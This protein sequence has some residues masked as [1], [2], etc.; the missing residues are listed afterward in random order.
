MAE[1]LTIIQFVE[2]Y[3]KQYAK[4]TY[5]REKVGKEWIETTYEQTRE[6]AHRIGAGLMALGIQKG[7]KMA[8]LSDG[9]NAWV[10]GELGMLYEGDVKV[11][12]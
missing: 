11:P 12:L 1:R 8:G 4:N 7:D 10:F 2:K 9:R 3:T 6:Q 5:L